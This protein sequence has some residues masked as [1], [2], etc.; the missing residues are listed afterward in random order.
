MLQQIMVGPRGNSFLRDLRAAGR[1]IFLWTV[2]DEIAMRWSIYK[3][4]DG[5]ITDD[6]KKY[7]EVAKNY[8]GEKVSLTISLLFSALWINILVFIFGPMFFRR[9]RLQAQMEEKVRQKVRS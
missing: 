5:V 1:S 6:P 7:L 2:N 3:G 4:V 8:K 9:A